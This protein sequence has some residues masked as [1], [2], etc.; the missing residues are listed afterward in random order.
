MRLSRFGV[1]ITS[2]LLAASLIGPAAPAAAPPD[3]GGVWVNAADTA[4]DYNIV[5]SPDRMS[6]RVSW[7]GVRT[8]SGLVGNF[9]GTL[10]SAGDKYV[11][12]FSV[13][14][15]G[16]TVNG[17]GT[18]GVSAIHKGGYPLL[19]V[20]LTSSTGV[21][22]LFKL[23]IWLALPHAAPGPTPGVAVPV[24]CDSSSDCTGYATGGLAAQN[25]FTVRLAST[26]TLG[27]VSFKVKAGHAATVVM[28]LN[29]TGRHLLN[30]HGSLRVTIVVTLTTA[31]G[32][33]HKTNAGTVTLRKP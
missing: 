32:L 33:P 3:L 16:V 17:T 29:K 20:I 12:T 15:A 14:E 9:T 25:P 7:R 26:T 28:R 21:K 31:G 1:A 6:M 5:V 4:S 11:G 23:E 19:N 13:K 2:G 22:T 27:R 8:H 30:K 10:A 18:F 24:S